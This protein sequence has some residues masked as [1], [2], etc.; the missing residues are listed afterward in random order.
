TPAGP[1]EASGRP[2][3]PG[4]PGG[5]RAPASAAS[6]G[7]A[8]ALARLGGLAGLSRAAGAL[9][10]RRGAIRQAV[11]DLLAA[12]GE[13]VAG[14]PDGTRGRAGGGAIHR[15][16]PRAEIET[17]TIA[18]AVVVADL[19]DVRALAAELPVRREGEVDPGHLIAR[20]HGDE[21]GGFVGGIE[22]VALPILQVLAVTV[23]VDRGHDDVLPRGDLAAIAVLVGVGHQAPCLRL[24]LLVLIQVHEDDERIPSL[25]GSGADADAHRDE[26]RRPHRRRQRQG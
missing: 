10:A 17:H 26:D 3:S 9:S 4:R 25:T 5:D 13:G 11:P 8:V 15:A 7:H 14:A 21:L 24:P 2:R 19:P 12:T 23:L 16:V 22:A 1:A 18:L 6:V 20:P